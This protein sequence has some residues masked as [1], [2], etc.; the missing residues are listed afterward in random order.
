MT[1][2]P[3][4]DGVEQGFDGLHFAGLVGDLDLVHD[5]VAVV[6]EGGHHLFGLTPLSTRGAQDLAIERHGLGRAAL[7]L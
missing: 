2:R 7:L 4:S 3:A 5:D 1:T 6:P